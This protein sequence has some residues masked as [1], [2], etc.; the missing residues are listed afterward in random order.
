MLK[1]MLVIAA[2]SAVSVL[3]V[4]GEID[5]RN[6]ATRTIDLQDGSIVYVFKS[7]KMAVENKMGAAVKT[8]AGTI[9]KAKDGSDVTMVGDEVAR[10]DIL[11]K[12]GLGESTKP[13]D[14][15]K[16]DVK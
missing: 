9:L 8:K 10:L 7:G 1:K 3:A 2:I 11:L 16:K 5:A 14:E 15:S 4:A 12:K 13:S 6:A